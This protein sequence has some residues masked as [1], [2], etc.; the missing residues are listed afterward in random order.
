MSLKDSWHLTALQGLPDPLGDEKQARCTC[1]PA[2]PTGASTRCSMHGA[3]TLASQAGLASWGQLKSG[4]G[5]SQ[6][7]AVAALASQGHLDT[8]SPAASPRAGADCPGTAR[9]VTCGSPS[10]L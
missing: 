8:L 9:D 10:S 2:L 6:E 5:P 4:A 7:A 3:G 1:G